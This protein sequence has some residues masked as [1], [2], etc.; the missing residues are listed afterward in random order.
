MMLLKVLMAWNKNTAVT[1]QDGPKVLG[2]P[3]WLVLGSSLS[4]K[5]FYLQPHWEGKIWLQCKLGQMEEN[6]R[7]LTD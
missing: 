7:Q 1:H 5:A 4:S 6:H 3:A 2:P